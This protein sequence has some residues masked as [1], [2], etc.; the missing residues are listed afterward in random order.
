MTFHPA[1]QPVRFKANF[2]TRR[3][4]SI[5]PVHPSQRSDHPPLVRVLSRGLTIL[6]A[7]EPTNDWLTNSEISKKT[8]VPKPTVSRLTANLLKEG[9]L[10]YSPDKAAYRLGVSVLSLGFI[11]AAHRSFIMHARP[12]MQKFADEHQVSVVLASPDI[13]SMVCNDVVHGKNM[14]FALR[15]HAGSR[16]RID[17]SAM[18]RALIGSM[19]EIERKVFFEKLKARDSRT[20]KALKSE[21]QEAV[22]QMS[23]RGYCIGVGTMEAGVNGVAVVIDTPEGAHT[24][25]LGCAALANNLDLERLERVVAPGLLALKFQLEKELSDGSIERD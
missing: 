14:V 23:Q 13:T 6:S 20:W 16:L 11:A 4:M 15:V 21:A 12:L 5:S 24:Y 7:F 3:Q 2:K 25:A 17:R 8:G 1:L 9:Y 22:R 19:A 10:E 18:G